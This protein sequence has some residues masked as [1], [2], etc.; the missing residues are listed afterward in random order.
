MVPIKSTHPKKLLKYNARFQ[1][2]RFQQLLAI[3]TVAGAAESKNLHH[4]SLDAMPDQCA[5]T[6]TAGSGTPIVPNS[7][8]SFSA[9]WHSKL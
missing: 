5:A 8:L 4:S 9:G 2:A 3:A 1:K 6:T 7:T